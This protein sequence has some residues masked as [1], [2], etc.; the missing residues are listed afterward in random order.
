MLLKHNIRKIF[1]LFIIL[2]KFFIKKKNYIIIQSYSPFS[3]SEN[4]RYLFEY[5]SKYPA[6]KFRIFWNT[7]E[8]N[9]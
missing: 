1:F 5:M 7:D 2:I 8:N 3:Y 9:F 4:S 6:G